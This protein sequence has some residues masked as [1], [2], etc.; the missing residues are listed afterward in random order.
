MDKYC[1][2]RSYTS[3]PHNT[4]FLER[5]LG[6][7]AGLIA[8]VLYHGFLNFLGVRSGPGAD[9]LG[10]I[11]TLLDLLH[12]A[13]VVFCISTNVCLL[14]GAGGPAW[15]H[16]YTAAVAQSYIPPPASD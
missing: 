9:L 13:R 14:P 16:V 4:S 10:N 2:V 6:G 7:F 3:V 1:L 8:P 11:H 5:Q 15:S 12:G